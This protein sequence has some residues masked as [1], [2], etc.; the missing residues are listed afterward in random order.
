MRP[1]HMRDVSE[2]AAPDQPCPGVLPLRMPAL[3]TGLSEGICVAHDLE[4]RVSIRASVLPLRANMRRALLTGGLVFLASCAASSREVEP[5]DPSEKSALLSRALAPL[6]DALAT[7]ASPSALASWRKEASDARI[8]TEVV[9]HIAEFHAVA[10]KIDLGG[11]RQTGVDG[12]VSLRAC[13]TELDVLARS[14]SDEV[15]QE[16]IEKARECLTVGGIPEPPGGWEKF[17][18]DPEE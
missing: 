2:H 14:S 9:R 16:I 10:E 1:P 11:P 3:A 8:L 15:S 12:L 13:A 5:M 18:P 7:V 4:V 6:I 17:V